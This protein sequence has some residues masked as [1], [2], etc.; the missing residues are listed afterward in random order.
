MRMVLGEAMEVCGDWG[1]FELGRHFRSRTS[2]HSRV[3][4][5][6][7]YMVAAVSVPWAAWPAACAPARRAIMVEIQRGRS[8]GEQEIVTRNWPET[9][10]EE[11]TYAKSASRR[12]CGMAIVA[13]HARRSTAAHSK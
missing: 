2:W 11:I 7:T 1:C 4:D 9:A 6:A 10:F 12:E 8:G 3:P 5:P 13:G